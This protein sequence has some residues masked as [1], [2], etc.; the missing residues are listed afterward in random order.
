[1]RHTLLERE[2]MSLSYGGKRVNHDTNFFTIS[3]N[4]KDSDHIGKERYL[5]FKNLI[6]NAINQGGYHFAF[7]AVYESLEQTK[8]SYSTDL[9]TGQKIETGLEVAH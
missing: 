6:I 9:R 4:L 1:M 7:N 8:E 3:I 5:H 2:Q